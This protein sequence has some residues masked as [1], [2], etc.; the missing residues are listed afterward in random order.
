[1]SLGAA[2]DH[3]PRL[4]AHTTHLAASTRSCSARSRA[5]A[6]ECHLRWH[7]RSCGRR[8]TQAVRLGAAP[9]GHT[10]PRRAFLSRCRHGALTWYVLRCWTA[11]LGR[12]YATPSVCCVARVWRGRGERPSR[13]AM[14]TTHGIPA[15]HA[16]VSMKRGAM[17]RGRG[18]ELKRSAKAGGAYFRHAAVLLY[19][20]VTTAL[21]G[22]DLQVRPLAAKR[23]GE[24]QKHSAG[25]VASGVTSILSSYTHMPR[26]I[27][28]LRAVV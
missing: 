24:T 25:I 22:A 2:G 21:Q 16:Q 1:M 19:A 12:D 14:P 13:V 6:S 20:V 10:V 26:C 9:S 27:P 15:L 7:I 5:C 17:A 23:H 11:M 28:P 3:G 18:S 4:T 8:F